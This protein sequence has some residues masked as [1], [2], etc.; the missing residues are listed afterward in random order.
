MFRSSAP[1]RRAVSAAVTLVLV[2]S[3]C[4]GDD[5][6]APT[7]V[8]ANDDVIF[9]SGSLPDT[10]PNDFP[11]PDEA[12]ISSTLV[13]PSAGTTEVIMRLPVELAAA[14]TYFEQN[15]P[16]RG[17]PIVNSE[18]ESDAAWSMEVE[19]D[20]LVGTIELET[21]SPQITEVVMLFR[22]A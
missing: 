14:V 10:L 11:I 5:G 7:T 16:A 17:F 6:A 8:A 12:I 18:A 1:L 3:A 4:S 21:A 15:L 9:G 19:R 22:T 2:A 20:D 13:V